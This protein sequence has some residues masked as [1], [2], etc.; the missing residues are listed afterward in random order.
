MECSEQA[1]IKTLTLAASVFTP[2]AEIAKIPSAPSATSPAVI[3]TS[4]PAAG[5]ADVVTATGPETITQQTSP[6]AQPPVSTVL[7][8]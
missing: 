3:P 5:D 4:S 6:S 2:G 1:P 8:Q 7:P